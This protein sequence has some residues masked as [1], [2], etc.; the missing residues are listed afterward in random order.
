[1]RNGMYF[2]ERGFGLRQPVG[3]SDRGNTAISQLKAGDVD[4]Q[5]VFAREGARWF[6]TGGIFAGLS[7]S[8][9]EAAREAM[10]AAKDAGAIVSYD[11]NYRASLWSERGGR[12]AANALNHELL[13]LADVVFG[14]E[15]FNASLAAYAEA[16]FRRAAEDIK[17]KFPDLK[18]VAT[19]LRDVKSASRHDLS[20]VCFADGEI[21]KA[22]DFADLDVLDR[23]GSGDAFAAGLIY[24]LL[25]GRDLQFS[26][27]CG[28]ANSA[29]T[30]TTAGDGSSATLAEV[31]SLSNRR[32]L[33]LSR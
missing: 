26:I 6:H 1:V 27:N 3:C 30:L 31:E 21:F 8:T 23:V 32:K 7:D 15:N 18:V 20:A 10:R 22:N 19:T 17:S 33:D 12:E 14:V 28:A 25:S 2:I 29:L 5:K 13:P 9:P 4:W 11:L 24:G 16:D